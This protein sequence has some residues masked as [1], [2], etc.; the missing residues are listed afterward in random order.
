[1]AKNKT[2]GS[3]WDPDFAPSYTPLEM[4]ELGVFEGKYINIIDGLP[5][6]W[7]KLDTVQGPDEDPDETINRFGVKSRKSLSYWQD[8]GWIKTDKGGWFHWY[9]LYFLGRRLGEEDK[10]QIGRWRSFVARHQAQVT[11]HCK[12][13]DYKCRP[14]QRQGLLQWA[15]NSDTP[16]SEKQCQKNLERLVKD[17]GIKLDEPSSEGLVVPPSVTWSL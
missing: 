7:Y 5:K 6:E 15:W 11:K 3:L 12:K 14:V 1:M 17:H 8:K 9:C 4:L 10:W 2:K 16:F 13:S